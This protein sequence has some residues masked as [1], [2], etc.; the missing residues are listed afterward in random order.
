MNNVSSMFYLMTRTMVTSWSFFVWLTIFLPLL[1]E[2]QTGE[3]KKSDHS[4]AILERL[5]ELLQ[6]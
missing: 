2:K 4:D 1:F 6:E 3:V 5:V